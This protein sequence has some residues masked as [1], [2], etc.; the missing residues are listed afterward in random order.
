MRAASEEYTL[1]RKVATNNAVISIY[2]D[3]DS[4]YHPGLNLQYFV[5][6]R[7][8]NLLRNNDLSNMSRSPYFDS[9]SHG[10]N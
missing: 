9:V 1:P 2:L 4:I 8:V 10:R 7:E 3:K 6:S 5:K